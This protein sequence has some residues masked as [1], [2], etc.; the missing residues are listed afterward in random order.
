MVAKG[1][2]HVRCDD[3]VTMCGRDP[4]KV[5]SVPQQ[6]L[7]SEGYKNIYQGVTCQ[8]CQKVVGLR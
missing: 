3:E 7:D 6:R 1:R 2:L 4:H 8:K 5:R